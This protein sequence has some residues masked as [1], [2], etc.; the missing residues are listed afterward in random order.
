MEGGGLEAKWGLGE[1]ARASN[2]DRTARAR[3]RRELS[4]R[5]RPRAGKSA[6]G[7][8]YPLGVHARRRKGREGKGTD[9]LFRVGDRGILRGRYLSVLGGRICREDSPRKSGR[10]LPK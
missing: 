6:A 3:A 4:R 5:P 10:A 1:G 9:L 8:R 7:D 2:R